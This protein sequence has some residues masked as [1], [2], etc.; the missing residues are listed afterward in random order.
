MKKETLILIGSWMSSHED[1]IVDIEVKD[2]IKVEGTLRGAPCIFEC[3][4]ISI[5]DGGAT[6]KP[7]V[8]LCPCCEEVPDT[9]SID[10]SLLTP[11]KIEFEDGRGATVKIITN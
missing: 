10:L 2:I 8:T 11:T 7:V 1:N 4:R 5:Q 3:D 6:I 9:I